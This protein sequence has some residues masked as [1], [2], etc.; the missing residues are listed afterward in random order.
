VAMAASWDRRR[1]L[2]QG[3]P[4]GGQFPIG[5]VFT[6][7]TNQVSRNIVSLVLWLKLL[8]PVHKAPIPLPPVRFALSWHARFQ[9][10]PAHK[11]ARE[12]V[13]NAVRPMFAQTPE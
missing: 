5:E 7:P 11:W 10:D 6:E 8:S 4:K 3:P 9:D 12:R 13:F 2:P 1:A